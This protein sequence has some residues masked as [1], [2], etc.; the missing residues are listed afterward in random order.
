MPEIIR[1]N[2]DNVFTAISCILAFSLVILGGLFHMVLGSPIVIIS[3]AVI[4]FGSISLIKSNKIELELGNIA[5]TIIGLIY[6]CIYIS[7]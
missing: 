2:S 1:Q 6:L 3:G 4:L 7:D 5:S